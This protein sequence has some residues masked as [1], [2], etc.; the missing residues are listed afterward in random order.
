MTQDLTLW[1][2]RSVDLTALAATLSWAV[3]VDALGWNFLADK[4]PYRG[5]MSSFEGDLY[6]YFRVPVVS[7]GN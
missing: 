7:D 4:P 1:L 6:S 5:K 3:L 2:R